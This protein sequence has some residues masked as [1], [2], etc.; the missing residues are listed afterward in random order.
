MYEQKRPNVP[1]DEPSERH[2][3]QRKIGSNTI[4]NI[5]MDSEPII[6]GKR[7]NDIMDETVTQREPKI[8][9]M[10]CIEDSTYGQ[11]QL[12]QGENPEAASE[13][14]EESENLLTDSDGLM[15]YHDALHH[16]KKNPF[17]KSKNILKTIT[18]SSS[19]SESESDLEAQRVR[20]TS[21]QVPSTG[22]CTEHVGRSDEM[23]TRCYS[24]SIETETRDE[25]GD[26]LTSNKRG[27]L[28]EK[29]DKVIIDILIDT[30][31]S[32][33]NKK[34]V[35]TNQKEQNRAQ[36]QENCHLGRG[37]LLDRPFA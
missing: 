30:A 1:E 2:A 10:L 32:C 7:P 33:S 13:R 36:W 18:Y 15:D 31:K 28:E 6:L 14:D 17:A 11:E 21:E 23:E 8:Q 25:S 29:G 20:V 34:N 16:V 5:N 24:A 9:K 35:Y 22:T 27:L 19:E 37:M 26:K 4:E 12:E 3:K